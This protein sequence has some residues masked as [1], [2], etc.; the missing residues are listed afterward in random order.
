MPKKTTVEY[1]SVLG[2]PRGAGLAEIK[3]AYRRL[4]RGC[5]PDLHPGDPWAEE[6]F[7]LIAEAYE[8]LRSVDGLDGTGSV[9]QDAARGTAEAF[10]DSDPS[11]HYVNIL[12]L[13]RLYHPHGKAG[14]ADSRLPPYGGG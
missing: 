14:N 12:R 5:H 11:D 6:E 4:A 9:T 1:C 13:F 7:K 3:V 2:V 10:P 8:K